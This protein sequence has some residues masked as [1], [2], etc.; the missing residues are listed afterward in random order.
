MQKQLLFIDDNIMMGQFL[1]QLFAKKYEVRWCTNAEEAL[2]WLYEQNMPSLIICDYELIGMN[3]LD[4]LKQIKNTG[5]FREIPV[6]M[7]SGKGSSE[8]R[9]DC[10]RE[11]AE[12]FILKPFNP[13]ELKIKV[14]HLL[15][16]FE[17]Q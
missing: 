16:K 10:L 14:D 6:I 3:G 12:D 13:T 11:G 4:F 2:N 1:T 15:N 8:N 5:F 7:L 17:V 9:I